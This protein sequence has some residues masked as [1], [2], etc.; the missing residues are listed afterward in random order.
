MAYDYNL[1]NSWVSAVHIA[2]RDKI[3]FG[4]DFIYTYGPYGFLRVANYYFPETYGYSVG[5]CLL[6]AI[7]T[8]A[9]LFKLVTLLCESSR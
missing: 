2:F 8:W 4:K 6:I 9:G 3:Q 7:A 1:D 5:F